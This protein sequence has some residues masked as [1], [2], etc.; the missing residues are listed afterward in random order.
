NN[1]IDFD[2]IIMLT[3]KLFLEHPKRLSYW[4]NKFKYLLVD[5]YQDTN[6]TQFLLIS[7]LSANHGNICVVGDES[8]SIYGFRGADIANILNFEKEFPSAKIIK[9]EENYRST[10]TILNAA[11]GVIKN[12]TSK[13]DKNLWTQNVDGDKIY[14][15][16]LNNE[17]EE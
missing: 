13:I 9:L 4:Q 7:L 3:V 2:D 16:T 8:Q 14:Y 11:N 12:N 6:K 15:N 10:Q 1:G 5:E 17:Y